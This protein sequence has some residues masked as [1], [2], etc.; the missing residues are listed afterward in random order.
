M[1]VAG[2]ATAGMGAFHFFLPSLF[3]WARF[4][5]TLPAEIQW[6]LCAMNAF[7]SLLLLVGGLA[8]MMPMRSPGVGVAWTTWTMVVFWLFNA[9]YQ[10]MWPF[11]T[12]G[13]RWVLFTFA[14]LVAL[15]YAG[16]LFAY[17]IAGRSRPAV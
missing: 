5:S 2:A 17:G 6:A 9:C 16:A 3:G 15:L 12:P 8:T 10:L 13:V 14:L 7:L 11:P 4:T 1:A